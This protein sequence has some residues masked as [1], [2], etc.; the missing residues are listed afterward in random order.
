MKKFFIAIAVVT[1]VTLN[2]SCTKD[3]KKD[4]PANQIFESEKLIIPM[5]IDLPSNLPGGNTRVATLFAEGV[6][7]YKAQI[8]AGSFPVTYEWVFVAPKATL[9]NSSNLKVGTH[10]AGP[11][12]LLYSLDT[13]YGQGY[14]PAKTA[15]SPDVS[16][17]D[18]LLLI[19]KV[20]KTPTGI[21]S[22]VSY[23]QRIATNG[24]KAPAVL[25]LAATDTVDVRYTAIYRFTSKN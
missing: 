20:G 1:V 10:G 18:W 19:P 14:A 7:K 24:G 6:Q 8:K 15:A 3:A 2:W 11:H 23:I 12:W 17:I 13:I 9:Y 22:N 16:S 25:P 21:F 5:G 4:S